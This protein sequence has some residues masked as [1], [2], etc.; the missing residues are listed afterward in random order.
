M[1]AEPHDVTLE[2]LGALVG[3]VPAGQQRDLQEQLAL[4]P[5]LTEIN[6]AGAAEDLVVALIEDARRRQTR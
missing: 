6:E 3:Q 2:L 5:S 4:I 1:P